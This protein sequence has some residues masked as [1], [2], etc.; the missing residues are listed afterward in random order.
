M[1]SM[2]FLLH[3]E[4]ASMV[5]VYILAI[6]VMAQARAQLPVPVVQGFLDC[7][8][9]TLRQRLR[10]RTR[11]AALRP[12]RLRLRYTAGP[13]GSPC[14]GTVPVRAG[15]LGTAPVR[16]SGPCCVAPRDTRRL[17]RTS[18]PPPCG[19][20]GRRR[21]GNATP[22]WGGGGL[23]RVGPAVGGRP[24]IAAVAARRA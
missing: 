7:A 17:C 9:R 13:S 3:D 16:P 5:F 11:A 18:S 14:V 15:L 6:L 23:I 10:A 8:R 2:V 12:M 21:R 4:M 20:Q 22:R 1:A 24:R 19:E